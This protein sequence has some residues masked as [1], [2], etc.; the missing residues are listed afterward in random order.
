MISEELGD[1]LT[2]RK[3]PSLKECKYIIEKCSLQRTPAQLKSWI[4]NQRKA[5]SRKVKK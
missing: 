3:L 5:E 2:L 4:D 1:I